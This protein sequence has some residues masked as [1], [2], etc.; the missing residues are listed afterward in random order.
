MMN[1]TWSNDASVEF[2]A[3]VP[4]FGLDLA[5]LFF[6]Q[7]LQLAIINYFDFDFVMLVMSDN[8]SLELSPR[9]WLRTYS[10]HVS[11]LR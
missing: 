2:H 1:F 3:H 9:I 4:L 11:G 8:T 10:G 7:L 5:S 6:F